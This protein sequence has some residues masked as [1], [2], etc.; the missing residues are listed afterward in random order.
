MP[1]FAIIA[2]L[3]SLLFLPLDIFAQEAK[4]H[5][6]AQEVAA[7]LDK[8]KHK[9]KEKYGVRVEVYVNIKNEPAIKSNPSDYSGE[10]EV[11]DLGFTLNLQVAADGSVQGSGYERENG[12]KFTLQNGRIEKALV[13]ATKDNEDGTRKNFEAVFVNRTSESGTSPTNITHRQTDFGLGVPEAYVNLSH[14]IMLSRLFYE[15]KK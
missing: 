12:E 4:S 7:S 10:Y 6:R 2:L 8:T 14:G 9:V 1:I 15:L 5:S 11:E 3:I 13:T